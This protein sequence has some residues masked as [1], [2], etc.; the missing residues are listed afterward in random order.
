MQGKSILT[1]LIENIPQ[2]VI[3]TIMLPKIAKWDTTT[4]PTNSLLSP[5]GIAAIIAPG[6]DLLITL[7]DCLLYRWKGKQIRNETIALE[8]HINVAATPVAGDI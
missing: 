5:I 2:L 4:N 6:V 1:R 3:A 8:A 7:I